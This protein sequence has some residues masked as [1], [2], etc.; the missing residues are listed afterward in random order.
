MSHGSW[1]VDNGSIRT[2]GSGIKQKDS[3]CENRTDSKKD[4]K[5]GMG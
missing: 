3:G 5:I 1:I 4:E 2:V